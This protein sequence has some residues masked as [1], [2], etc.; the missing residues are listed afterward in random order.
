MFLGER[1][2]NNKKLLFVF[3]LVNPLIN[4]FFIIILI[5]LFGLGLK[6]IAISYIIVQVP[7]TIYLY[8]NLAETIPEVYYYMSKEVDSNIYTTF[9]IPVYKDDL[10][11]IF[12]T[13][14][15]ML[16]NEFTISTFMMFD[17][18]LIQ[19]KINLLYERILFIGY[20]NFFIEV[21]LSMIPTFIAIYLFQ[22]RP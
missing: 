19:T 22:E 21:G 14:F 9:I 11:K 15:I 18:P 5:Y 3:S 8:S 1:F 16:Y 20:T 17:T 2:K 7:L 10:K 4:I 12:L 13:N 6:A